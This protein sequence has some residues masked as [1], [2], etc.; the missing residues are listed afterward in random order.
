VGRQSRFPFSS[1]RNHWLMNNVRTLL[2]IA[3]QISVAFS[4]NNTSC[5]VYLYS[6]ATSVCTVLHAWLVLGDFP[7]NK[8]DLM[9]TQYNTTHTMKDLGRKPTPDEIVTILS[10]PRAR[11]RARELRF[12]G[13]APCFVIDLCRHSP[14]FLLEKFL[15]GEV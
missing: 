2:I 14:R 10:V 8:Y 6:K 13:L 15:D 5:L 3:Y 11:A 1:F 4:D 12:S 7:K 9:M